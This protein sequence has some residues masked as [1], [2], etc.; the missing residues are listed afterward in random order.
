MGSSRRYTFLFFIFGLLIITGCSKTSKLKPQQGFINVKG[1]KIWYRV[2]GSGNNTPVLLIHGGPGF[3]SYYLNPLGALSKDRP[4][5]MFDLL[6]CGRSDKVNDTSLFTHKEQVEQVRQLLSHLDVKDYYLYGHSC[7]AALATEYYLKHSEG[8]KG[9]VLASPFLSAK[10]W[11]QDADS[12]LAVMPMPARKILQNHLKGLKQDTAALHSAINTYYDTY[13]E[14]V[15]PLSADVDSA[16]ATAGKPMTDYMWGVNDL[17]PIG[18]L[19]TYDRTAALHL[20]KVPVL[21]VAGQFDAVWPSTLRFYQSLI[22]GSQLAMIKNA[23]HTTMHDNP[24]AD[25]A[26]LTRFFKQLDAKADR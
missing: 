10:L 25:V 22:Q 20:I 15:H 14:R 24:K 11:R 4:V 3:T 23:S 26:V 19:G 21:F 9:I 1:G 6:G 17:Y 7:G 12:L 18:T 2:E 16:M 13:Y 8:I 5:I